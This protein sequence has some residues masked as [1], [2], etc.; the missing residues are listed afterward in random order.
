MHIFASFL[1]VFATSLGFSLLMVFIM[2]FSLGGRMFVN[3]VWMVEHMK[4]SDAAK[5]TSW[6]FFIDSFGIFNASIYFRY[7]SKDWRPLFII[8]CAVLIVFTIVFVLNRQES[9]KFYYSVGKYDKARAV[10]TEI[11]RTNGVLGK[12]QVYK[13]TFMKE[14]NAFQKPIDESDEPTT[15]LEFMR[16]PINRKNIIIYMCMAVACSF[17]YYLINFY[18][19]YLPGDIF[20]NQ[21]VNSVSESFANLCAPLLLFVTSTKKG[22]AFCF[23]ACAIACM[24]VLFA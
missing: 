21:I 24:L 5:A 12:D 11:G 3:Y 6:L 10:L 14:V 16:I 20:T 8:P 15:F 13:K 7:I 22:F 19:K 17:S 1:I 2:G 4:K 9:P 23:L 18:V